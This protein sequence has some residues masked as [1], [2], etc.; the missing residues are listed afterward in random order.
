[1][2]DIKQFCD[3]YYDAWNRKD[4][5]AILAC[6]DPG[7]VFKSPNATTNGRDAFTGPDGAM[8][9]LDFYCVQPIGV[10][11]TAE[12]LALKNGLVVDDELFFDTRPFEALARARAAA[13]GKQ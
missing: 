12:R 9:A 5:N 8:A 4:L 11:P 3:R 13:Q 7:V 10:C 1:M 2:S 6:I